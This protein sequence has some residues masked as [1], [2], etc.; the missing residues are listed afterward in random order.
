M[1]LLQ[2]GEVGYICAAIKDVMDAHIRNI[3]VLALQH[4]SLIKQIDKGIVVLPG[5]ALSI[6]VVYYSLFLVDADQYEALRDSLAKL[7]LN[8]VFITYEP[9][10]SSAMGFGFRCSFLDLLHM[11]IVQERL[12]REYNIDLI[13]TTPSVVYK[14][15]NTITGKH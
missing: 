13:V 14:V 12:S 9:E 8:N 7:R 1:K 15:N 3:I 6:P 11:E 2:P 10:N 5:Y 4:K